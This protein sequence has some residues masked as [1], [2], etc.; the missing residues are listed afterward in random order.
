MTQAELTS[1]GPDTNI[2]THEVS[3]E[4][5]GFNRK[6][7][8]STKIIVLVIISLLLVGG[9][10]GAVSTWQ[11]YQDAQRTIAQIEKFKTNRSKDVNVNLD[12]YRQELIAR[13]KEYLKSEIQTAMAVLQKAYQDAHHPENLRAVYRDP[14]QNA[15]NTAYSILQTIEAEEG[16]SIEEKQ[17]RAMAL[18]KNLR[19]GPDNKDY[20]WINDLQPKMIMHPYKPE[21]DGQDVSES[22]DSNGKKLFMEFVDVCRKQGEGF[23]DY[24]WPKYGAEESYPKLSYVKLF[25]PWGWIV[26]SGV[27]MEIAEEKLKAD[28]A[29]LIE[30]LRYG[31]EN[32]DYFW[33]NDNQPVMVMHPYKPELNGRDVSDM[34]DSNG[35]KLFVEFVDV[36]RRQDEGFV[37]YYWPKYGAEKP[38]PKLSFVRLFKEW[39]WIV[40]TGMYVDD[41]EAAVQ[42]KNDELQKELDEVCVGLQQQIETTKA[43]VRENTLIFMTITAVVVFFAAGVLWMVLKRYI[44]RPIKNAVL[45]ARN[46]AE[47]NLTTRIDMENISGDEI[48]ELMLALHAMTSRLHEII[49]KINSNMSVLSA[50]AGNL[51]DSSEQMATGVDEMTDQ[52]SAVARAAEDMTSKMNDMASST[53]QTSESIKTVATSIE[54]MTASISEVARNAEEA[55][56][57]AGEATQRAK[58]SNEK[59]G[60]LDIAADEIGKVIEVI[61]DIAEQT[62]LLAL[63]ATIE[64]A[65]AGDAGKGFAVVATEVKELARQTAEATEGIAQ[66]ISSIQTSTQ[67]TV[68]SISQISETIANVNEVS[69]MIAAAVEEQSIT[70]KDIAKHISQV[71]TV[72]EM[73]TRGVSESAATCGEITRNIAH[74][75]I[76]AKRT[77][78]GT[79]MTRASGWEL[80]RLA[81]ELQGLVGHFK[82]KD[83]TITD[84]TPE[85]SPPLPEVTTDEIES[86]RPQPDVFIKWND[87]L[88][89][90]VEKM[91]QQHQSLIDI[92]N[93]L[94]KA[95]KEKRAPEFL[96]PVID[97]LANYTLDH[98]NSEE[99]YMLQQKYS[100]YPE[101][102]RE[103]EKFIEKVKAFEDDFMNNKLTVSID[104]M[105]FLRDW[106]MNH[107]QNS[108]KKY[109]PQST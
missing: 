32:K 107:I 83:S 27:Y 85:V 11:L 22:V 4:K 77:A 59:I 21:M 74:V 99:V 88:S 94:H 12:K 61:Q 81:E 67:E 72:S 73:V 1:D 86:G 62:N 33:I 91:D 75:D 19:Y 13:K 66:R 30:C 93:K 108:D 104:V 90:S 44:I 39:N 45:V 60:H 78:Q 38:Q 95:M 97:E 76:A 68:E 10:I 101:H 100:G 8:I 70:T 31:P 65:R 28:A 47:G 57:V 98:F 64:A 26:G 52:S 20:F 17:A 9:I 36:C 48:G 82:I 34:E 50:A 80:S 37:E 16:L 23:V 109:S 87:D 51:S 106:L 105:D 56:K 41:I 92:I 24:Y 71:A 6:M 79:A 15:V 69:R 42:A 35:K 49:D 40:G 102:K 2:M 18:I 25:E 14:L 7:K 58:V 84:G 29:S 3:V 96:G 63:N 43:R 103:H 89:V 46:I 5:S 55:S 53:E 54:Q